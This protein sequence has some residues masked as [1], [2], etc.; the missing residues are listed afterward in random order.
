MA[1]LLQRESLEAELVEVMEVL[2]PIAGDT[3]QPVPP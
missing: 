2:V 3:R 1:V